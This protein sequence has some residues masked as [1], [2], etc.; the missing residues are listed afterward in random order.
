MPSTHHNAEYSCYASTMLEWDTYKAVHD[1]S[2]ANVPSSEIAN[3]LK[4]AH[5][6]P[7]FGN[8]GPKLLQERGHVSLLSSLT[9]QRQCMFSQP[10]NVLGEDMQD[11]SVRCKY[12]VQL[13]RA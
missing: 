13:F 6:D 1:P 7:S 2:R 12:D 3:I 9:L 8:R 10:P 4:R 5:D 11:P